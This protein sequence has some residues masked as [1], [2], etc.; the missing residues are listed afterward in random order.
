MPRKKKSARKTAAVSSVLAAGAA[1]NVKVAEK[2]EKRSTK[3]SRDEIDKIFASKK[4]QSKKSDNQKPT[5][6]KPAKDSDHDKMTMKKNNAD[7]R[8]TSENVS[9]RENGGS[10]PQPPAGGGAGRRPRKRTRDGLAV[11]TEE[12]LGI[13]KADAGGTMTRQMKQLVC[14]VSPSHSPPQR[15][16]KRAS[17]RHQDQE[18]EEVPKYDIRRFTSLENQRWYEDRANNPIINEKHV[19]PN[20]DDHY[21]ITEAFAKL[22]WQSILNLP[23]YTYPNLVREFYANVVNKEGHSGD[24]IETQVRGKRLKITRATIASL[25]NCSNVGENVDLKKE[26]HATE[27]DWN[28]AEAIQRFG[29][30]YKD[31]RKSKKKVILTKDFEHRHRLILYIFAHN[32]IPKR[33]SKNEVRNGDLYFLDKM[34]HGPGPELAGIPL[35]SV[36]ISHMRTT[37]RHQNTD[38]CFGF[39]RLLTHLFEKKKVNLSGEAQ[40]PLKAFDE[41][42]ISTLSTLSILA[43]FGA[44][45]VEGSKAEGASTSFQGGEG[46]AGPFIS[47]PP[48]LPPDTRPSLKKILDAIYSLE[49]RVMKCLDQQGARI[50]RIEDHLGIEQPLTPDA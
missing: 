40:V 38:Y 8:R 26:F 20:V 5:R 45:L 50:R 10:D 43:N 35:P 30:N 17:T 31:S 48:F 13:G 28:P 36:L 41:I 18:D 29:T 23:R 42:T 11:Y 46:S 1:T 16:T 9:R 4:K 15:R 6:K 47:A 7:K 12:E 14:E 2:K 24:T 39:P 19:A 27:S 32:I 33:S 44:N 37:A 3:R 34:F 25:L 22:G 21:K 49:T